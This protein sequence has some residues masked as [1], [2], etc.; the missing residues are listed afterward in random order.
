MKASRHAVCGIVDRLRAELG[1]E[2]VLSDRASLERYE[3]GYRYGHGCA[4]AVV[5]P[6]TTPDVSRAV[7][8]CVRQAIPIVAQGANTGLVGASVP[9]G[10]GHQVV[11]SLE[12]LRQ[13][14]T[15]DPASRVATV[16]AGV[17]LAALN[18]AA[19]EHG[20]IF[21]VDLSANPTIGGLVSTN[22]GGSR[23]VKYGDVRQNVLGLEVVLA[24]ADGTVL[25]AMS[26]LRK[27]SL[28][29][30][31]KQLFI[32]TGGSFGIVTAATLALHSLPRSVATAL[33]VPSGL[34]HVA[35]LQNLLVRRLGERLSAFEGMSAAAVASA[36][37]HVPGLRDPFS[38]EPLPPYA[39]LVEAS[40]SGDETDTLSLQLFGALEEAFEAGLIT[41]A[42]AG[43][44]DLLWRLRH[45]LSEG[46]RAAGQVL[47]FDISLPL[48]ALSAFHADLQQQVLERFLSFRL[49]DFGHWGDGGQHLNFV[50]DARETDPASVT[51]LRDAVYEVVA[52][53]RGAFSA[54]HGLGPLNA[55][56]YERFT[57]LARRDL[58]ATIKAHLDPA[59]LLG[60][61]PYRHGSS[62]VA[63]R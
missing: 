57:S 54:E 10:T 41:D 32:G 23:V 51:A 29:L 47:G 48:G 45:S 49:C 1:E 34:G 42:R 56:Y 61:M 12:R 28:G 20:L 16:G 27:S 33:V 7:A 19:A 26:A 8:C 13:P 15:I 5:L 21:P 30:D 38:G 3:A 62:K 17:D 55:V 58:A 4:L 11:I 53:H 25:D 36:L 14:I 59:G 18:A 52:R 40:A 9:D 24:D 22:A 46:L 31:V 2:F 60:R 35:E 50:Y 44:A 43:S 37:A 6:R 63:A 39:L